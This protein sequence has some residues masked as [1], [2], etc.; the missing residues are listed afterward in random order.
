VKPAA[1]AF[2]RDLLAAREVARLLKADLAADSDPSRLPSRSAVPDE[3]CPTRACP[4][5]IRRGASRGGRPLCGLDG[6]FTLPLAES[7][8]TLDEVFE[9]AG[10]MEVKGNLEEAE[11]LYRIDRTDPVLAFCS[12]M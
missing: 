8:E 5:P 6:Q 10:E 4:K 12:A 11:R 2:R 9:R 3:R 1:G 7:F